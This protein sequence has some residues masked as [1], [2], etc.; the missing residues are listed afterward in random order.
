MK[1]DKQRARNRQYRISEKTLWTI[2]IIGGAIGTALGMNL[3]RIKQ[4]IDL[5]RS[6][7]RF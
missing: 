3:F 2:A 7:F 1:V 4:N 5:S 6:A